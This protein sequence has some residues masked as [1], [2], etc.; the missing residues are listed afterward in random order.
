MTANIRKILWASF[1]LSLMASVS[2]LAWTFSTLE[3]G[4]ISGE[5]SYTGWSAA[6]SVDSGLV[7]ISSMMEL[8]KKKGKSRK[9]YRIGLWIFAFISFFGNMIHGLSVAY[10]PSLEIEWG[11]RSI[12]IILKT[13][14]LA[15]SL[16]MLN[17][18][19]GEMLTATAPREIIKKSDESTENDGP[20][21]KMKPEPKE[22]EPEKFHSVISLP[23]AIEKSRERKSRSAEPVS[24]Q[25][26]M[27]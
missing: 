2:H 4:F 17:I 11:L 23:D 6:I 21:N 25:K 5:I 19:L 12:F 14:I 13:L 15:G 24:Q 10:G 7:A 1:A 22:E 20:E 3:F 16:P 26:F 27:F 8:N 9:Y 18:Y